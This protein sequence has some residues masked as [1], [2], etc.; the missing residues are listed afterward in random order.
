MPASDQSKDR[1][2]W[3]RDGARYERVDAS[4]RPGGGLRISRRDLGPGA[5]AAWGGDEQEA[6][7]DLSPEAVAALALALLEARFAGRADALEAV[8]EV[9]E[10]FGIVARYGL[11]S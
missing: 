8:R 6:T 4:I 5:F 2:L 1:K 7:L 9:C 11:W 10:E 3:F